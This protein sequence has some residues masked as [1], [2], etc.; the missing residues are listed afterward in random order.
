MLLTDWS[1]TSA[2]DA[3]KSSG[4][5]GLEIPTQ[6]GL[7]NGTNTFDCSST[8]AACIGGGKRY[9]TRFVKGKKYRFRL[10]GSQADGYIKFTIDNHVLTVIANDLVPIVPYNTTNVILASG[11]RYDIIV[12]ANREAGNFWLRSLLQTSCNLIS[13][14]KADDVLGIIR[15]E[16]ADTT[17]E[18]TS[19]SY[20]ISDSCGDEPKESLVPWLKNT[21][22]AAY[23]QK[24]LALGF[25]YEVLN[26]F[27]FHWTVN[28]K[29]LEID[30]AE[31]TLQII[32]DGGSAFPTDS[33]IVDVAVT[34]QV[35][36][37]FPPTIQ[38]LP[39]ALPA[40][41]LLY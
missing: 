35:R 36:P 8:D 29:Y 17:V 2:F 1:H 11:Q 39:F 6:N 24:E 40:K 30:W 27:K 18:P 13:N 26:G 22:G 14:D 4:I 32:N 19:T 7:I 23:S 20:E 37:S 12:T 25:T 41:K 21:V 5:Y 33:N 15:Y 38:L 34:N 28:T 10:V 9:E 3:W 16:G 31:P